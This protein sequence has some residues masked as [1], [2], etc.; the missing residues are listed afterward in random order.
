MK[1]RQF[2]AL[3]APSV[4]VM[5]GFMLVPLYQTLRWSFESVN[6]GE[7]GTFIGLTNYRA[8]LGDAR[9]GRA[10]LFTV[11]LTVVASAFCIVFGYVLAALVNKLGRARPLVLG[12]LLISYVSPQVVGAVAFSWL[13]DSNF[14][15]I[16]DY[17]LN[18]VSGGAFGNPLW[19]TSTWPNRLIIVANV[20][21][22]MLPFAMLMILA[23][24]QGVSE[25]TLEAAEIDGASPLQRHLYVIIPSIRGVLGFVVLILTMD[26]IRVFDSLIPLA[27]QSLTNGNESLMVYIY[28][29]AFSE[30]SRNLGLG[31]AISV[32][33]IILILILLFPSIRNIVKEARA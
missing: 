19:F 7:A 13:F 22:F 33:T 31:S 11:G 24:L 23:G 30:A 25:E 15:G 4:V 10:V 2:W 12:I 9:L 21:W 27:P 26:V 17:L 5:F 28:R 18:A 20:V 3:V 1:R 29:V 6:Y 8:A 14:G 16:V 32:L